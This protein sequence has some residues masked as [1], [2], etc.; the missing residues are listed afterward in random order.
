MNAELMQKRALEADALAW[1]AHE[2]LLAKAGGLGKCGQSVILR[3]DE[4]DRLITD[5]GKVERC[6]LGLTRPVFRH[7]E[8]PLR[9]VKK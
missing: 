5:L 1:Q 3:R 2:Y 6:L 4:L 9:L 8:L 7:R